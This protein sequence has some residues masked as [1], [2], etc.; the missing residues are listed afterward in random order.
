MQ[1]DT[2]QTENQKTALRFLTLV[3]NVE[4]SLEW[5]RKARAKDDLKQED[6]NGRDAALERLG[7]FL[8]HREEQE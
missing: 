7:L 3:G 4:A 6:L 8:N 1:C 2:Q 5:C